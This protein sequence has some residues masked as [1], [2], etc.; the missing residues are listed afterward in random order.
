MR[1]TVDGEGRPGAD[2]KCFVLDNLDFN[3]LGECL[4]KAK[5]LKA[6]NWLGDCLNLEQ[7]QDKE[8]EAALYSHTCRCQHHTYRH[9]YDHDHH[10]PCTRTP[11][12]ILL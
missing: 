8:R 1:N 11:A 9:H 10:Q 3:W 7:V 6:F 12:V 4:K 2:K 5:K